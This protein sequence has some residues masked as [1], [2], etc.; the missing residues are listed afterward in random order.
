MIA[1]RSWRPIWCGVRAVIV[2]FSPPAAQAAKAA[3]A[4]IPIVFESGNDPV[5][6]G[7]VP[8]T[9]I[10]TLNRIKIRA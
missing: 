10:R 4:T 5:K 6:A 3:T 2:A 1:S 9:R 7:L 8:N